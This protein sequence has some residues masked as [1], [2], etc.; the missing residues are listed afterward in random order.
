MVNTVI[1]ILLKVL[2]FPINEKV[3]LLA[4]DLIINYKVQLPLVQT[5]MAL[6]HDALHNTSIV[7]N[8]ELVLP[9]SDTYAPDREVISIIFHDYT[10]KQTK[11]EKIEECCSITALLAGSIGYQQV[12]YSSGLTVWCIA[13][14]EK[15]AENA[16]IVQSAVRVLCS[17]W[18]SRHH[19]A[20]EPIP[21]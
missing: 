19:W 9:D 20:F 21:L 3:G 7:V 13:Q 4:R 16:I 6:L 10:L 5:R 1:I 14:A 12:V 18:R 15:Y 8:H 11:E 17:F 2:V